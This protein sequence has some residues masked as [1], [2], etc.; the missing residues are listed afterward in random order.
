MPAVVVFEIRPGRDVDAV[1]LGRSERPPLGRV[2][3]I[4]QASAR[5]ESR[6]ESCLRLIRGHADVDVRT[7]A[8]RLGRVQALERD[9][10][11]ASVPIDDILTRAQAL[12]PEYGGPEGTNIAAGILRDGDADDLDLEGSG[13]TCNLR[14]STEIRR[15]S[16]TSRWLKAPYSPEAVRTVTPSGRRSTSGKWPTASATSAIAATNLAPCSNDLTR[17]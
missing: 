8:A 14:A 11:V 15:A 7:A 17:K 6:R 1:V 13:S 9:V 4:G 5:C 10:W 12:V 2:C 3:L 16:S